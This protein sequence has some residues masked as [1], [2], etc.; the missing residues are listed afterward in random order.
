MR[1]LHRD[2]LGETWN[3]AADK[4]LT[5]REI[6]PNAAVT[7]ELAYRLNLIRERNKWAQEAPACN[8][9]VHDLLPLRRREW[10]R[11]QGLAL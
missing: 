10:P 9:L 8:A 3:P 11:P 2:E 1:L 4:R 6:A 7:S 5:V